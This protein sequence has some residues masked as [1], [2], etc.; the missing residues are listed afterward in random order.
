MTPLPDHLLE[1]VAASAVAEG[2]ADALYTSVATPIGPLLLVQGSRG[3]VR[4]GFDADAADA[5]LAAVAAHLGPRLVASRRQL[6][7]A[8]ERLVA[9]LEGDVPE[10]DLP[11]DLSLA[12]T[13]FRREA[14]EALARTTARGETVT[15]S[16]LAARAGR[17]RAARAA[18]TACAINPVPLV[19][20]C[21]RVV[22]SS[23]GVG[24]Y[25]GGAER[26]LRLLELEGALKPSR[27]TTR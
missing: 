7:G 10:I 6:A 20:P 16:E 5:H 13:G 9:Y 2:L 1:S 19:V 17:P 11:F 14:L 8:G 21:H 12:G 24:N 18:G 22:P 15:Y 27:P 26:K 23:G 25:G 3:I 4:I